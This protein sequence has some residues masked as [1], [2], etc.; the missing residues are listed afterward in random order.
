VIDADMAKSILIVGAGI[1][2]VLAIRQAKDL[3]LRVIACDGNPSAPGLQEGDIGRAV[4]IRDEK[5]LAALA[6]EFNVDGIFCHAVEIPHIIARVAKK[7][8]LPGLDPEIAVRA[9]KKI[10]R[11][12]HL[13]KCNIPCARFETSKNETEL[14]EKAE[15]IGFPLV[16]K[17][18]DSAG[19]RGVRIVESGNEL[20]DAYQTAMKYS[21]EKEV[22][23]EELLAGPQVSTES[24]AYKGKVYTF[25]FADRNYSHFYYPYFVENGI[26]FP[27]V[28]PQKLQESICNL[29]EKTILCLGIDFG[30]AKGDIIVDKGQPKIIEM[31]ARTS[32]GWFGAGSIPIATGINMLKPLIQMAVRDAPDLL[33][34][35]PT[36]M[37]GCAQR[38]IIPT[39]YGIYAGMTGV[40]EALRMPGVSMY[41]FFP[42]PAGTRIRKATNHAERYGQLICTGRTREEAI[43]RCETAVAKIKIHLE[44]K[45]EEKNG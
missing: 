14:N 3:G 30:A 40:E 35:S 25:A 12:S 34:L 31:A 21:G 26:N 43:E 37:L 27:S 28:L 44:K 7:L 24:L 5:V 33:S 13:T 45:E 38:Y 15:R 22:L 18:V 16:V 17:P 42:P 2:Q 19:S 1:E 41:T 8:N 29:V 23:L 32:G 10:M 9:T 36:R 6:E 4:D 39:E 11:I 20:H